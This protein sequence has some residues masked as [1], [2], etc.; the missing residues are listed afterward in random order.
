[1][2]YI[3]FD[4]QGE[5]LGRYDATLHTQIP[6]SAMEISDE[7][8]IR[9]IEER[10]GIWRLT[11]GK[12]IKHPLPNTA[13]MLDTELKSA[14]LTRRDLLLTEA[15]QQTVGMADAYIAGLLETDDMRR[16]KAF[17]TYKLALNKIDKQLGYPQSVDWPQLPA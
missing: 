10:D 15:D 1:M 17:A 6:A 2:R 7:L 8:F 14:V 3:D 11:E 12:V 16:F 13:Q 5:L 9:T 4:A